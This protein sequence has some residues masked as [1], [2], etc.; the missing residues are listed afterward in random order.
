MHYDKV[1]KCKSNN[2]NGNGSFNS[3][4]ITLFKIICSLTI[5]FN[6]TLPCTYLESTGSRE[7]PIY[8]AVTRY[9]HRA[10]DMKLRVPDVPGVSRKFP[11]YCTGQSLAMYTGRLIY[12]ETVVNSRFTGQLLAIYRAPDFTGQLLAIYRGKRQRGW[13]SIAA[14]TWAR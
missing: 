3:W 8:R 7:F 14:S 10:V 1:Q 12:R 6:D 9:V 11:V 13:F 2:E 5:L 4:W